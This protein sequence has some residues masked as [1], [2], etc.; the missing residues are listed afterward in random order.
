MPDPA[1]MCRP[2]SLR[3]DY[4]RMQDVPSASVCVC[5]CVRSITKDIHRITNERILDAHTAQALTSI[6][7]ANAY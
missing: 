3:T 6:F 1:H 4:S 5:V 2:I 7:Q